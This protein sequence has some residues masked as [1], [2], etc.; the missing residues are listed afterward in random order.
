MNTT[1]P[2]YWHG[3]AESLAFVCP[4]QRRER[5]LRLL[6]LDVFGAT[7]RRAMGA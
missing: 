7:Y 2:R 5:Y 3:V 4:A 6:R 1:T